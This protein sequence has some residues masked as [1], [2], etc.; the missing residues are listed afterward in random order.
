MNKAVRMAIAAAGLLLLPALSL[1]ADGGGGMFWGRQS[2]GYPFLPDAAIQNNSM[3]LSYVGGYGY[4]VRGHE[5]SG[6]FGYAINDGD[7]ENGT[8]GGFGGVIGGFRF[9]YWPVNVSLISWTGIGGLRT[10][11]QRAAGQDGYFL[12]LE[13]ITLEIG[14][15]ISRWFMPSVYAGYQF[16]GNLAPGEP[17]SE[18]FTYTP[19][20]GFRVAWGKFY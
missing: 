12:F 7:S 9:V 6:G 14:V 19:V 11:E 13:E 18:F 4:G 16:I 17:F 10:A 5:I 20:V 1:L 15:P 3:D 8:A 2:A